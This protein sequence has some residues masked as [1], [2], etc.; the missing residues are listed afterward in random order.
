MA[1]GL[2]NITK[3]AK[4]MPKI[5]PVNSNTS[6]ATSSS[7]CAASKTS[8]E[9]IL[10]ASIFLNKLGLSVSLKISIADSATPVADA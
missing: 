4:D 9:V 6:F 2:E 10:P 5:F 3:L 7:F 1:S 8:L